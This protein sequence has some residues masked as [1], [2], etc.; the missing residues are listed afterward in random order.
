M[1]EL[2]Y[3][4]SIA[5]GPDGGVVFSDTGNG[6]IRR[7]AARRNFS[8]GSYPSDICLVNWPMI[9]YF[10]EIGSFAEKTSYV[11][12]NM[13][14]REILKPR[15]IEAERPPSVCASGTNS[16]SVSRP[17]S[18]TLPDGSSSS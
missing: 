5:I 17:V 6:R 9:D 10:L 3:P 7:I 8:P 18:T 4:H 2:R 14:A 15:D 12:N 11:I 1:A 16:S 13:F